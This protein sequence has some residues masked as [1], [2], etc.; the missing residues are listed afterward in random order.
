MDSCQS[1]RQYRRVGI[2]VPARNL[3]PVPQLHGSHLTD[4]YTVSLVTQETGLV[5]I[6]R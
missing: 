3:K 2:P 1:V 6:Q 4:K 5:L